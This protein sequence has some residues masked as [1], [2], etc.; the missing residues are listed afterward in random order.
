MYTARMSNY[1][2]PQGLPL[3]VAHVPVGSHPEKMFHWHEFS[4][5]A[6]VLQGKAR[7][8]LDDD[9]AAIEAGDVLVIHPGHCHAYDETANM[10]LINIIYDG[11]RLSMPLLDGHKLPLFHVLFPRGPDERSDGAKPAMNLKE[12]DRRGVHAMIKSLDDELKGM[13][14]GN[15]LGGLVSFMGIILQMARLGCS[16]MPV[17]RTQFLIG[18]VVRFMNHNFH[19]NISVGELVG[20]AKM[21]E[22]S[23]FRHFKELA[24]CSPVDYLHKIRI[25]RASEMLVASDKSIAEIASACGYCDSNHFCLR[26]REARAI[27]PRQFRLAG[28]T[29]S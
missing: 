18:D 5:I 19:R 23:L 3:W 24:G 26:F 20:V 14:P 13:R 25:N 27:T 4:E 2:L 7:H 12:A 1:V 10:E 15:M 22:R 6:L 11:E 29:A 9:S 21:S 28:K 16:E 8:L 17:H